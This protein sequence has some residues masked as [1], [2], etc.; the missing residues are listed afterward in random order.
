MDYD[1]HW[2]PFIYFDPIVAMQKA[3]SSRG[4]FFFER[5]HRGCRLATSPTSV[6]CRVHSNSRWGG[7]WIWPFHEKYIPLLAGKREDPSSS[8]STQKL[9]YD[10][11]CYMFVFVWGGVVVTILQVNVFFLQV[12]VYCNNVIFSGCLFSSWLQ[13]FCGTFLKVQICE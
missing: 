11:I 2:F 6:W 9:G 5:G 12:A 10:G 13:F 1:S 3:P 8:K 7:F 4:F